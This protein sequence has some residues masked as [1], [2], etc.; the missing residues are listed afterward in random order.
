MLNCFLHNLFSASTSVAISP[1]PCPPLG[2]HSVYVCVGLQGN[3]FNFFLS[4]NSVLALFQVARNE[5]KNYKLVKITA[6]QQPVTVGDSQCEVGWMQDKASNTTNSKKPCS[7][8]EQYTTQ[9]KT[10]LNFFPKGTQKPTQ[11]PHECYVTLNQI[12][13]H[14]SIIQFISLV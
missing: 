5:K 8:L 9:L 10:G 4:V 12:Q 3:L 13:N 1:S 11:K 2:F 7:S 6:Q 14:Q